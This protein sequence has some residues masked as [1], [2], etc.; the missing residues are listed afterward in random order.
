VYVLGG[1]KYSLELKKLF[2]LAL[3]LLDQTDQL[4]LYLQHMLPQRPE[5]KPIEISE[6]KASQL[7]AA[8]YIPYK[9]IPAMGAVSNLQHGAA[10]EVSLLLLSCLSCRC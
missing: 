5:T 8:A 3:P 1:G 4:F 7:S 9:G 10:A 2:Q 6:I